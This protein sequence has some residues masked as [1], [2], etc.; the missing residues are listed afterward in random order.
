MRQRRTIN[1]RSGMATGIVLCALIVVVM[2]GTTLVQ[3]MTIQHRQGRVEQDRRQC[4]WLV[5]SGIERAVAALEL[6]S[7]YT[8]ET[9]EPNLAVSSGDLRSSVQ[10]KTK[11]LEDGAGRIQITV[12][13][14]YLDRADQPAIL[15]RQVVVAIKKPETAEV[16]T[17]DD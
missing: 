15:Q 9:W 8:G 4:F 7:G 14:E 12:V 16:K 2:L 13:A 10:I 3:T 11:S 5:E 1:G 6:N 17:E